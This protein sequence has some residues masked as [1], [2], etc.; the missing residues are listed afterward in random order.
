MRPAD[1]ARL[2]T[3]SV[4]W[5]SSFLFIKLAVEDLTPLQVAAGRITIGCIVLLVVLR[6]RGLRL[7]SGGSV[8][9]AL[10]V[11]AVVSNVIPFLLITWGEE[12]ITSSLAAILNSTT[13]LFTAPLAFFFLPG[14]RFGPMRAAGILIGFVGAGVIVGVDVGEASVAGEL[15]VVVA[16][17]SYAIGFVFAKLRLV[18]R[19]GSPVRLSAGQLVAGAAIML[20]MAGLD[21]AVHAPSPDAE[22]TLSMLAL[23]A[24]GTGL[25]YILYYRLVTD[26][27]ATSASFV[28]YLIPI[29]GAALGWIA[30]D[31]TLGWNALVGA[32]LVIVGIAVAERG[33]KEI[34]RH[35]LEPAEAAAE[36]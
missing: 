18:G 22:A 35:D 1:F 8:W 9:P 14:E 24:L 5:G 4:I 16:S 11:M 10:L 34:V 12:R 3:L 28:T 2:V 23:G 13:P 15:A 36:P 17:F 20:P 19:H 7:P 27:G 32:A 31:E 21:T 33:S 30:L 29:F 26:V 25:A 6:A